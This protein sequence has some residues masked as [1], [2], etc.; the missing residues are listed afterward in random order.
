MRAWCDTRQGFWLTAQKLATELRP[1]VL[2]ALALHPAYTVL[3]T[4]H[5]LGAAV[6]SLL[7]LTW[8]RQVAKK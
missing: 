4:G 6:A 7:A 3:A 5:S 2:D 8:Q 1:L